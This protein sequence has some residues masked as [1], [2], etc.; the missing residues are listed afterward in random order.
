[1]GIIEEMIKI[2]ASVGEILQKM[3]PLDIESR[4]L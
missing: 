1:M 4:K 3:P 2:E